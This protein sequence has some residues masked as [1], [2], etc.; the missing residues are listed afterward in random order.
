[1]TD[2]TP[3]M[4]EAGRE[5]FLSARTS[6]SPAE[7]VARIYL[8]M[9]KAIPTAHCGWV[10]TYPEASPIIAEDVVE[11]VARAIGEQSLDAL[12]YRPA[13]EELETK[14]LESMARAAIQALGL[15]G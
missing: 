4:I 11:R 7:V 13:W 9:T 3:E 1:M 15:R 14:V 2:I 12:S 10:E 6:E 5:I 8:A